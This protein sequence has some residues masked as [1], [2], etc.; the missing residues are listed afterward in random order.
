[1]AVVGE[2]GG[3][4][5]FEGGVSGRCGGVLAEVVAEAEAVGPVGGIEGKEVQVVRSAADGVA[6]EPAAAGEGEVVFGGGDV[7]V[8]AKAGQEKVGDVEGGNGGEN[9][10]DGSGAQAWDGGAA[11]VLDGEELGCDGGE[12]GALGYEGC[13][14]GGVVRVE[15][16]GFGDGAGEEL[17]GVGHGG[18]CWWWSVPGKGV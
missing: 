16:D 6:H 2:G 8:G 13:G 5:A 10:D 14:P 1:M 11:D 12:A 3:E 15:R 9:V 18:G 4:R 17:V 7:A